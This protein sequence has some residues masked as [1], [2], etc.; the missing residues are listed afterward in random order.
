MGVI[1][2]THIFIAKLISLYSKGY[3]FHKMGGVQ[4]ECGFTSCGWQPKN[5]HGHLCVN[6]CEREQLSYVEEV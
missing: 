5:V 1:D 6:A 4:L 3:F 2:G